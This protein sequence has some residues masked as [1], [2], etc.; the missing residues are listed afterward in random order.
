MGLM[1]SEVRIA[2]F[3][4]RLSAHLRAVR[5]GQ[6]IIVKDRETPIARVVPYQSAP[7]RLAVRSATRSLREIDRM[8]SSKPRVPALRP[9][10][11]DKAL[12]ETKRDYLDKWLA[13]RST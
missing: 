11:L 13:S 3:K 9:G 7:Q 6:E 10:L 2:D 12:H 5:R 1:K 4:A 8:F